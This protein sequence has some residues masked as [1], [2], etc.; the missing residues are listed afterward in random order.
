MEITGQ[1]VVD[2]GV[3]KILKNKSVYE[4]VESTTGVP[5]WF[6]GILHIRESDGNLGTYLGN[7]QSLKRRTTI[8]PKG[9]GPFSSFTEGAVDAYELMGYD[10]DTDWSLEHALYLTEKFNGFGYLR[11]GKASPYVWGQTNIAGL[12]KY[13]SDGKYNPTAKETQPGTAALLKTLMDKDSSISLG[14][15]KTAQ[16]VVDQPLHKSGVIISSA[17]GAVA[18]GTG[19][20][21]TANDALTA[22][23]QFKEQTH[24]LGIFDIIMAHPWPTAGFA[25]GILGFAAAMFFRWKA[26]RDVRV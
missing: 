1:S 7:G 26:K 13:V 10:G 18:V 11:M 17:G 25:V 5:W 19:A 14:P 16:E 9:R 24:K 20:L 22:A 6:T 23:N 4:E 15:K 21:T 2:R 12:G 3:A 8:A